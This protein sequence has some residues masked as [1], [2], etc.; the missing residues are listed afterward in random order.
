MDKRREPRVPHN[1]RFFVHVSEC[2][3]DPDLIGVS[4]SC[5]G[6]DFSSNG[7]QFR[8]DDLIPIGSNLNITIGIGAPFPMFLLA[9]EIKWT[10]ASDDE[11]YLGIQLHESEGT[12]YTSWNDRF[13][14][15]FS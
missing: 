12:D 2:D 6:V 13:D 15:I 4:V 11:C 1:I 7:L 9:G 3:E 5:E 10:R 8:T 14:E